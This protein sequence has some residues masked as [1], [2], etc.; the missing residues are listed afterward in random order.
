MDDN[1]NLYKY[2]MNKAYEKTLKVKY[3]CADT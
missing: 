1:G 3:Y 2:G